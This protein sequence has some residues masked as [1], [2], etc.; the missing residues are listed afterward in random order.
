M[1]EDETGV[2][3]IVMKL[4]AGIIL[5]AIGLGIG[6]TIYLRAGSS[7]EEALSFS[8]NVGADEVVMGRPAT[9]ENSKTVQVSIERIL[10][11]YNKTVT[12]SYS[13]SLTGVAITFNPPDGTPDFGS[14]MT[15]KVYS[16][17][18]PENVTITVKGTGADG[19]AKSDKFVLRIQ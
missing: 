3:P 9:G 8:V 10:G 15:I 12:L 17:A 18:T 2:E 7:A 6:V 16:N 5:F 13:P 1:L 19:S 4:M 14:T 11:D